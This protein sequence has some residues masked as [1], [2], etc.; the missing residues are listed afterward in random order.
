MKFQCVLKPLQ[1]EMFNT[2]EDENVSANFGRIFWW[3]RLSK[4]YHQGERLPF[5]HMKPCKLPL[6][7]TV[8]IKL[9]Y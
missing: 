7:V 4:R 2:R 9:K 5:G 6:S 3:L 1:E 8:T